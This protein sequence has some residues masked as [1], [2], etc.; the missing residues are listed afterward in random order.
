[1]CVGLKFNP[2]NQ[3]P[4]LADMA[5]V[6]LGMVLMVQLHTIHHLEKKSK[7]SQ[8]KGK[9]S[10]FHQ[11]IQKKS[12]KLLMLKLETSEVESW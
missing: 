12:A 9:L 2:N 6:E 10:F 8:R 5:E 3:K 1:M 4:P 11:R 7:L